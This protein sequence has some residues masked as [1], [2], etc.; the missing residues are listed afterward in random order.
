MYFLIGNEITQVEGL[1][2][3][4]SLTELV[5]D[6]NKI[7]VRDILCVYLYYILFYLFLL[8]YFF[9]SLKSSSF[10]SQLNLRELHLE[11]NRLKELSYLSC[12]LPSLERLY[13]GMNRLQVLAN[14]TLFMAKL[15]FVIAAGVF[16][17]GKTGW[18]NEASGA[19]HSQ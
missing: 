11:E 6:R 10:S 3:L 9:Q 14:S 16:R 13:L 15:T 1:E 17:V 19:L 12:S 8:N 18:S 7:K 4:K 2:A 5:L